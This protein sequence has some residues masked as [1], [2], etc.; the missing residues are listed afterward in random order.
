[1]TDASGKRTTEDEKR[2]IQSLRALA[3]VRDTRVEESGQA[4]DRGEW[5]S[6]CFEVVSARAVLSLIVFTYFPLF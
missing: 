6:Y 3:A 1:M 4:R 2:I 5:G